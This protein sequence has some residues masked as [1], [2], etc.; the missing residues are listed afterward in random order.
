MGIFCTWSC[1]ICIS[2]RA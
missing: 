2:R 1:R